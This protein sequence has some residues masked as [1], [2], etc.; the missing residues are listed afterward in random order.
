[1]QPDFTF[2]GVVVG[3]SSTK[4]RGKKA[5]IKDKEEIMGATCVKLPDPGTPF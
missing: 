3:S 2:S 1:M 5:E 4:S